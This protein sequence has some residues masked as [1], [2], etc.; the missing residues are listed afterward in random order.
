M[1][2]PY[3]NLIDKQWDN[4][5]KMYHLYRKHKPV[6]EYN[7]TEGKV[8]CYPAK[9]YINSLSTRTRKITK[10]NYTK[11]CRNNQFILFIRD[12]QNQKYKSYIFDIKSI[13][14]ILR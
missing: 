4:I 8:F 1:D 13:T 10:K 12:E 9:D 5:T 3:I 6:V 11:A 2:D 7:I 14:L